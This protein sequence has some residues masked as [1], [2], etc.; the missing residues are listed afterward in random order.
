MQKMRENHFA[1]NQWFLNIRGDRMSVDI[2]AHIGVFVVAMIGFT[3]GTGLFGILI[4]PDDWEHWEQIPFI[5]WI[6]GIIVY[7]L[8]VMFMWKG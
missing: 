8:T 3:L 1:R 6:A 7:G 2:F 5:S 4:A